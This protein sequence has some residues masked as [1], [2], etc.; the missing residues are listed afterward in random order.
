[1][2]Q[3]H[4]SKFLSARP[5][6]T[7]FACH[8]HHYWPDVTRDAMV[9]YWDDSAKWVDDKWQYFFD[10]KIPQAQKLIAENLKIDQLERIVFA[11]NTHEFVFRLI[12]CFDFSSGVSI[13]TTDSEFY[14]FDRQINRLAERSQISLHK[15]PVEPFATFPDRF[16]EALKT[17]TPDF[18]FF[19]HVFFNSGYV[20]DFQRLAKSA[21]V[22]AR[23]TVIDGY[24]GFMAIPTDLSDLPSG[25]FYLAGAYKY[26]Q[27]GEGCCFLVVP[28]GT[29]ERPLYTGWFAELSEL[30]RYSGQTGYP[31]GGLRFAGSTM[32]F[33]ALYR[34]IASLD[35]F[36]REGLT[37][38]V[39]HRHIQKQQSL[40]LGA[41]R[42]I[43][44]SVIHERCLLMA[45]PDLHGHFLTF[46]LSSA[47]QTEKIQD[48]L[49]AG[50]LQTDSRQN[51]LRFGFGLYH[52]G[53]YE[54]NAIRALPAV[55]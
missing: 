28:E 20:S 5:Q 8:S 41:L 24:H 32:D 29:Q 52:Q 21:A 31:R 23:M 16:E 30:D 26:A 19:S 12:S 48:L 39:I 34:L 55:K 1:M 2:Y 7:H 42:E 43:N 37:V 10:K 44:H 47:E 9:E 14:S 3:K 45:N 40:F 27:G 22:Y 13:V 15:V 49:L 17:H 51:R 54:L 33:S 35:L 18:V 36:R 25:C 53:P 11:P 4:Y 38:D 46:E 50:G 6:I